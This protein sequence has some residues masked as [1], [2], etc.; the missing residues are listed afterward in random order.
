[1]KR[2]NL[3]TAATLKTHRTALKDKTLLSLTAEFSEPSVM[4]TRGAAVIE[5]YLRK[6]IDSLLAG[7]PTELLAHI[8]HFEKEFK[9][10]HVYALANPKAKDPAYNKDKAAVVSA[11]HNT[12]NYD[13]FS[14]PRST[15]GAYHLVMTYGERICPY[16]NLNHINFHSRPTGTKKSVKVLEMRPP[17]DHY[18]PRFCY[19]YLGISLYNLVPCCH[20]CNSSIKL[21][22]DPLAADLPHPFKFPDG[23]FSFTVQD[24]DKFDKP[25]KAEEIKISF[26][27]APGP[28]QNHVN[29]FALPERYGWYVHEIADM[30]GKY[31][32]YAGAPTVLAKALKRD[33]VLPF[34]PGSGAERT[35]GFCMEDIF[36][37]F[38]K[39]FSK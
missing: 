2:L 22:K 23:A 14:K 21:Q 20:Q 17:L 30:H 15:W 35:L 9:W 12:F 5:R 7:E 10:F 1:M 38:E 33:M 3:F 29:F 37:S 31:L 25:V 6:H 16:C 26:G 24:I 4:K 13:K 36:A 19:P 18:Y 8:R 28:V 39:Q 32:S 27:C 34:K 11:V